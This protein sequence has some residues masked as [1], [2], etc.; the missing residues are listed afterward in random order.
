MTSRINNNYDAFVAMHF[1][2]KTKMAEALGV[3]RM[4]IVNWKDN[5][6]MLLTK[7]P[8]LLR[9]GVTMQEILY[10]VGDE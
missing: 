3:T 8:E 4:T 6:K 7:T 2:S 5:R 1:G 9:L 10:V